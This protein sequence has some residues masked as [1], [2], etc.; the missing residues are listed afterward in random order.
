MFLKLFVVLNIF[1]LTGFLNLQAMAET[2]GSKNSTQGEL[3]A[4]TDLTPL[5]ILILDIRDVKN[6]IEEGNN[7][8]AIV[9]LK[10]AQKEVR[11]VTEF[12][13]NT[14][15]ITE[16]RIKTGIKLLKN[17]KVDEALDLIQTA[18]DALVEEGFADPEDFE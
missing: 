18:I 4:Q 3:S 14:K 1:V 8:T 2:C 6:L 13:K 12:N 17:N 11:K 10:S 9:I 16:K 15:K 7:K 5:D